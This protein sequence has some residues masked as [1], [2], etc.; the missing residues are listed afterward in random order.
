MRPSSTRHS[1]VVIAGSGNAGVLVMSPSAAPRRVAQGSI[2]ATRSRL[3]RRIKVS[4]MAVTLSSHALEPRHGAANILRL[5]LKP[6]IALLTAAQHT[7]LVLELVHR[8]GRQLS[9][10]MILGRIVMR[11]MHGDSRM[12]NLG[13]HNLPLNNWLDRLMDMVMDMLAANR[14]RH[15][16]R[17][18]RRL[19]SDLIAEPLLFLGEGLASGFLVAVVEFAVLGGAD[20]GGVLLGKNF[21][22]LHGLYRAVVVVLVDFSVYG[23]G[24][25]LVL[26]WLDGFVFDAWGHGFVDCGVVVAGAAGEVFDGLLDFVHCDVC[27]C[28]VMCEEVRLVV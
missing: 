9:R 24:H 3:V 20:V 25:F 23:C 14:R 4:M 22:V 8:D 7:T 12:H 18:R 5:A 19:Y 2:H 27:D 16:L 15:A 26:D 11:L 28:D 21:P 10:L 6:I 13:L 17:M 1:G